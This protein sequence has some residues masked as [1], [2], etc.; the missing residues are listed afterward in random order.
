[1]KKIDDRPILTVIESMSL[2]LPEIEYTSKTI[3]SRGGDLMS[4]KSIK[5]EKD[6]RKM[7]CE[8]R[9]R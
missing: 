5:R 9:V 2:K 1:M 3:V 7:K 6:K 8:D 4:K